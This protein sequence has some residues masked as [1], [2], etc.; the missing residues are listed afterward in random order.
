MFGYVQPLECELRVREQTLYRAYYCGLCK[1]IGRRYGLAAR[2]VLNYDCT[3]LAL[4]LSALAGISQCVP[5]RCLI[6]PKLR[7]TPAA[8]GSAALDYAADANVLLAYEQQRDAWRDEKKPSA[9]FACALLYPAFCRAKK[10]RPELA[11]AVEN[12]IAALSCIERERTPGTDAAA[13]AFGALLRE[14]V[15]AAPDVEAASRGPAEWCFFNLGRWIYLADAWEDR[16]RDRK[17]GLYNPFNAADTPEEDASFA[18]YASLAEA[19][20]G[21][22]LVAF[23]SPN[24]ILDNIMHLGCRHRTRLLFG[25]KGDDA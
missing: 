22:D 7:K 17:R 14:I 19:E 9:L 8:P 13:C 18:L 25:K 10:L 1:A 12:G 3:F 15:R 23:A 21:Y 20:K 16:E 5:G 4:F 11:A 24:G 2:L 6:K